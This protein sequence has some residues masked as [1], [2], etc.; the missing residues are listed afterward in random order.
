MKTNKNEYNNNDIDNNNNEWKIAGDT[1]YLKDSKISPTSSVIISS[2]SLQQSQSFEHV[3]YN[4][5]Y[6]PSGIAIAFNT[7]ISPSVMKPYLL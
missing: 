6:L 2:S 1:K 5:S 3:Q 4:Y 7:S